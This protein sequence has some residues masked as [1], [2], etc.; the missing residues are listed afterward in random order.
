M[1]SRISGVHLKNIPLLYAF[2]APF[3]VL[4]LVAVCL[5]GYISFRNGRELSMKSPT[6][7]VV[8]SP[9]ESRII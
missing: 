3:V 8:K 9:G 7:Y 6:G 5:V 4:T 1:S 2:L